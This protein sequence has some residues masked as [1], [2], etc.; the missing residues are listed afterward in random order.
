MNAKFVRPLAAEFVGTALFVFLGV[1]SVV[2]HGGTPSVA[3]PL[4]IAL[5]HG[6]ALAILVSATMSISGGHLNPAVTLALFAARKVDAQTA[7]GYVA[8]Q[9]A[10]A[11]LGAL[12]VRALL[13]AGLDVA[14]NLGTPAISVRIGVGQ[15][16]GIEA[17]LTFCLMTAVLGT[18][19]SPEA[20]K[21]GGFGIGL[22]VFVSTLVA[23]SLTG[24]ALN[25]ARAFGPALVMGAWQSHMI[26]WIGPVGGAV[27]AAML[28]KYVL[29]PKDPT[30]M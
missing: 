25:P 28:W 21:I 4:T 1:G 7:G 26:Y 12:L 10:G 16:L 2:M 27:G 29:L 19:V 9:L 24:A 20:P 17:L 30:A 23:G 3:A 14:T 8:V 15:G 22:T 13:P 6:V 11:V 18:A 5:A